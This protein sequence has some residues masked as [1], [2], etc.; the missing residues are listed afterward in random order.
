MHMWWLA[1]WRGSSTRRPYPA[2]L[3]LFLAAAALLA[4]AVRTLL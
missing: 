1:L 3:L 4:W 2:A